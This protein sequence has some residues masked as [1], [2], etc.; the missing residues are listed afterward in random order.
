[1]AFGPSHPQNAQNAAP[2]PFTRG[3]S[4]KRPQE[5][6]VADQKDIDHSFQRDRRFVIAPKRRPV[7][8]ALTA[9]GWNPRVHRAR[10]RWL[11]RSPH[12]EAHQSTLPTPHQSSLQSQLPPPWLGTASEPVTRWPTRHPSSTSLLVLPLQRAEQLHE[13]WRSEG[14]RPLRSTKRRPTI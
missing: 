6:R 9:I 13:L 5:P 7:E 11:R 12:R 8:R 14:F 2:R 10:R 4:T 3:R 1:M